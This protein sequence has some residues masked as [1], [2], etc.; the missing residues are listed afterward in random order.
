MDAFVTIIGIISISFVPLIIWWV[1]DSVDGFNPASVKEE[2]DGLYEYDDIH[3]GRRKMN[4]QKQINYLL[5]QVKD[6]KQELEYV[7]HKNDKAKLI[8]TYEFV[9]Y[10]NYSVKYPN[11]I[12]RKLVEINLGTYRLSL[13]IPSTNKVEIVKE[14]DD[15]IYVLFQ[16]DFSKVVR[17]IHKNNGKVTEIEEKELNMIKLC[18]IDE[19]P[20]KKRGRPR[21]NKEK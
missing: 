5:Q 20:A 11:H 15:D 16:D 3:G 17:K 19:M 7:E 6:L 1:V 13:Y 8:T 4:K 10:A 18:L 2:N 12:E 9:G 21:K 14:T